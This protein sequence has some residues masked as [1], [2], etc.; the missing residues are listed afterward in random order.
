MSAHNTWKRKK[1]SIS[2]FRVIFLCYICITKKVSLCEKYTQKNHLQLNLPRRPSYNIT[3]YHDLLN[4]VF[5][6]EWVDYHLN[7]DISLQGLPLH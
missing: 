7:A 5:A 3:H 6:F 4:I 2:V 1:S